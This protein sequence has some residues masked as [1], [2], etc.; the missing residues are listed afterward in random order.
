MMSRFLVINSTAKGLHL[1]TCAIIRELFSATWRI[2]QQFHVEICASLK[3]CSW[4]LEGSPQ[5]Q[6]L[7]E[8]S[9]AP[10]LFTSAKYI[11]PQSCK[12]KDKGVLR[13][14][15]KC[16]RWSLRTLW[17][18]LVSE[19]QCN[20]VFQIPIKEICHYSSA[21]WPL[22]QQCLERMI[23]QK[24]RNICRASDLIEGG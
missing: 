15:L 21:K 1:E 4:L 7:K 23:T 10:F 3:D 13:T 6:F 9:S 16:E 8:A 12:E 22:R 19:D 2:M 17:L 5:Q 24:P 20:M 14:Q 11:K 18:T